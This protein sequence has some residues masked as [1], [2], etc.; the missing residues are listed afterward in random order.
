MYVIV[1]V[2]GVIGGLYTLYWIYGWWICIQEAMK[3]YERVG[4]LIQRQ[5]MTE[6]DC[7]K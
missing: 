5:K 6:N 4:R 1:S 3:K 2:I 7:K